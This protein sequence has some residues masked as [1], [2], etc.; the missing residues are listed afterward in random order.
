MLRRFFLLFIIVV[1]TGFARAQTR[2]DAVYNKYL[3]FNLKRFEGKAADALKIGED[4]L[5][6]AGQLPAK[7]QI[8]FFNGLAKLY[9]DDSQSAE[10]IPLYEKVVAAQPNYYVAHRALGY[11]YLR[12]ADELY[13]RLESGTGDTET[14]SLYKAAVLKAM[15]HLEKAEAC[16]PS[17]ETLALIKKL[18]TNIHDEAGLQSLGKRLTVLAKNCLDI[19]SD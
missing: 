19:L 18:Y 7:S 15:P 11:L 10:A 4:I 12:P 13:A 2:A 6:D 3:D 16:D 9:E 17:D 5:S 14:A 8:S 1:I